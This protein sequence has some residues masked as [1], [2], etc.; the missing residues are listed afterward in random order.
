MPP[1]CREGGT[2]RGRCSREWRQAGAAKSRGHRDPDDKLT[3]E[4]FI[5]GTLANKEILRLIQF[6]PQ[7]VKEKLKE[8]KP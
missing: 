3:E 2:R 6:E 5:E 7:K 8:K 4:E 1:D